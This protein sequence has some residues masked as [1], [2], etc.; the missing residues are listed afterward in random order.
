MSKRFEAM[1]AQHTPHLEAM[2]VDQS[3]MELRLL[4]AS[5][6]PIG[7]ALMEADAHMAQQCGTVAEAFGSA[8]SKDSPYILAWAV[9]CECSGRL[10]DHQQR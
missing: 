10:R 2:W 1:I 4:G 5:G 8:R 3:V 9:D 6:E 7:A